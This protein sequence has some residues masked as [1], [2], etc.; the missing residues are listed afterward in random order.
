MPLLHGVAALFPIFMNKRLKTLFAFRRC[1]MAY[2]LRPCVAARFF[3][4]QPPARQR[5]MKR[6]ARRHSSMAM[7][8]QMRTIPHWKRIPKTPSSGRRR[9]S[10]QTK[11]R[12]QR[13]S[14]CPCRLEA[15]DK[16]DVDSTPLPQGKFD[17]HDFPAQLYSK[18]VVG[19]QREKRAGQQEQGDRRGKGY[20]HGC[21]QR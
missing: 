10:M 16:T 9:L 14:G 3:S 17:Q 12:W 15:A 2:A 5:R 13:E 20:Q 11:F 6:M 18:R 1:A 4:R 8:H 19:K 21:P 7:P